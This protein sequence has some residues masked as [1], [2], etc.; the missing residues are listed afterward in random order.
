MADETDSTSGLAEVVV[1]GSLDIVDG[2]VISGWAWNS[3]F[4]NSPV[5]VDLFAD[6]V[7]IVT[8]ILANRF[9]DDLLEAGKGNGKHA[10]EIPPPLQLLDD[11]PHQISAKI[12]GPLT[13]LAGSPMIVRL[14]RPVTPSG[15]SEDS[16]RS[17][18]A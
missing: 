4:P 12:W 11:Q 14:A 16:D 13:E 10:F 18:A 9:R 3:K 1:E 7:L 8:G 2:D 15:L 17:P 5:R 6:D